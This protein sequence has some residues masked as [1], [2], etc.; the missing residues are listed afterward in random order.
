MTPTVSPDASL[1]A[2]IEILP[3]PWRVTAAPRMDHTWSPAQWRAQYS[4]AQQHGLLGLW[5]SAIQ[6]DRALNMPDDIRDAFLTALRNAT[7]AYAVAFRELDA[8]V[9]IFEREKIPVVLLKGA[10]L[11]KTL[12]PNPVQRPFG[13]LD[14]LIQ[15]QDAPRVRA[16]LLARGMQEN[17]EL[18]SG[19]RQAH[20]GEMGFYATNSAM[21]AIDVHWD[22]VAPAY[23]RRHMDMDWFWKQTEWQRIGEHNLSVFNPTAQLLHLGAHVGLHHQDHLRLIWL[24]DIALLLTQ[25]GADIDWRAA[26]AFAHAARLARPLRFVLEQTRAW[27]N[28]TL[29]PETEN[30]FRAPAF[31]I[32]E[33]VAYALTTA[34]FTE[35]RI[36]MDVLYLSGA[37]AKWEFARGYLFPD[38]AYMR[39]RYDIPN[40]A[41]LSFYYA[42]R[43]LASVGKAM[44]SVWSA[45]RRKKIRNA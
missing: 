13:D 26:D 10:A 21:P 8:L 40:D 25:R 34:Q 15:K 16:L 39:T 20:Y 19:F 22:L 35:A 27:W 4:N 45:T 44:R 3:V 23:Y 2:L 37:R 6:A 38:A 1:R 28:L 11:S 43:L 24:Y 32:Q 17:S 31:D 41:A 30:L 12:Y 29:P 18:V 9:E 5:F 36:L 7:L 33:R 42:R 14:L